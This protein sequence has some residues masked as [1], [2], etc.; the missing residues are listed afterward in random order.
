MVSCWLKITSWLTAKTATSGTKWWCNSWTCRPNWTCTNSSIYTSSVM[1]LSSKNSIRKPWMTK[2]ITR[3]WTAMSAMRRRMWTDT[4]TCWT[5]T[6]WPRKKKLIWTSRP[7][8]FYLGHRILIRT[9]TV[10]SLSISQFL[11]F[12]R[13]WK[14][15]IVS[16]RLSNLWTGRPT[17][18]KR[19][20]ESKEPRKFSVSWK[21]AFT[22]ASWLQLT[23]SSL[24]SSTTATI[25]EPREN[26]RCILS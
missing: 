10:V 16:T 9:L 18:L 4:L 11:T 23:S 17:D 13:N 21:E 26:K 25:R 7:P 22:P 19:E 15:I 6:T 2:Y 20:P 1:I 3:K 5:T 24:T 12:R 8:L 14:T